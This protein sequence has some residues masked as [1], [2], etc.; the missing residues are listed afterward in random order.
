LD[1][2]DERRE[3]SGGC[4]AVEHGA[5]GEP[6]GDGES[7][8]ADDDEDGVFGW[9]LGN[10]VERSG[11]HPQHENERADLATEHKE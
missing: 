10:L 4:E 6:A 2:A 3:A 7:D 9:E 1:T 8:E 5:G 11:R